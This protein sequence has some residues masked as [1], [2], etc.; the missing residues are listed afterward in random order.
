MLPLKSMKSA[1]PMKKA[2]TLKP[3]KPMRSAA[4]SEVPSGAFFL[5]S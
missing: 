5:N 2:K 4:W 3:L 1:L